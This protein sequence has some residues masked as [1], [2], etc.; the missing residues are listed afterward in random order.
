MWMQK[1]SR[2]GNGVLSGLHMCKGLRVSATER[3]H[4]FQENGELLNVC[5]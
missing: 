3:T 2:M 1:A 4:G 5:C